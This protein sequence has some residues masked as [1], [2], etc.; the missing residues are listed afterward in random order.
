MI[1][2]N[3]QVDDVN[4][5]STRVS[6]QLDPS[7][8]SSQI[9]AETHVCLCNYYGLLADHLRNSK[10]C[11][12]NLRKYPQ[13]RMAAP[14]DEVFIVKSVIILR[15]CPAPGCPGGTHLQIPE[16]CLVWWQQVGWKVMRWKGSSENAEAGEIKKR[17]SMFRRNFV[18]RN[19]QPD[20]SS[21]SKDIDYNQ[22]SQQV[23]NK[24]CIS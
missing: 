16:S 7:Q 21:N 1:Q 10:Q 2:R 23:E 13:L 24:T 12:D 20:G 5:S 9:F 14:N 6:S 11:L 3:M 22:S 15:G 17:E 4:L 18:R 19:T 8:R